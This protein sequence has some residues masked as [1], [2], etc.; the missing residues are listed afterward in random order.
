MQRLTPKVELPH[1]LNGKEQFVYMHWRMEEII[2]K[3]RE[4]K[5]RVIVVDS[6]NRKLYSKNFTME[7]LKAQTAKLEFL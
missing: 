4:V 2:E 5:L 7:S 6:C 1:S 3:L